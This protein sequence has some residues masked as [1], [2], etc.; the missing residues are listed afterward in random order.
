MFEKLDHLYINKI[1]LPYW[2]LEPKSTSFMS[3]WKPCLKIEYSNK[4]NKM[5]GNASI[6]ITILIQF[7]W[8]HLCAL[9]SFM[10]TQIIIVWGNM[11]Q[12]TWKAMPVHIWKL[13]HFILLYFACFSVTTIN[14]INMVFLFTYLWVSPIHH[15]T[16]DL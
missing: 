15:E 9:K 10:P 8:E 4:L 3:H 11:V 12:D 14:N 7:V 16:I 13:S 6:V 1:T 2:M 5:M